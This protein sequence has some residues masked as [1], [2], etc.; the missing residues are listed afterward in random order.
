MT[1]INK[2]RK[3][4]GAVIITA[5]VV[6]AVMYVWHFSVIKSIKQKQ[7][8]IDAKYDESIWDLLSKDVLIRD[9]KERIVRLEKK[10]VAFPGE[11]PGDLLRFYA[12]SGNADV[13]GVGFCLAIPEHYS[14]NQKLKLVADVLME[15]QFK[16]GIIEVKRI[17]QQAGKRIA[18][19][20]LRE[21]KEKTWGW[22]SLYF[23][24]SC[25]GHRTTYILVNTFLQPDYVGKWVDGVEFYYE[26][27]PITENWTHIFLHGTKYRK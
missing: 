14:L 4:V 21:S 18:I 20:E 5:L 2:L 11:M 16:K 23:Q 22:K 8:D 12:Y 19:V 17:E 15:Y 1:Q 27:K 25:G 6:T 24:G 26:G 3:M 10:L 13:E 9:L 7:K